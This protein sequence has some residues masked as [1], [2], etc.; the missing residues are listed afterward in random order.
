MQSP[1]KSRR[2]IRCKRG[3]R[4]RKKSKYLNSKLTGFRTPLRQS[5]ETYF[6]R[7]EACII[8]EVGQRQT[9]YCLKKLKRLIQITV[10][11][12]KYADKE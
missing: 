4:R 1:P 11:E 2:Q 8:A 5:K 6:G 7:E 10:K 12:D 9:D 3:R